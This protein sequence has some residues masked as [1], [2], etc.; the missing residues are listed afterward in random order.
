MAKKPSDKDKDTV[1]ADEAAAEK[2]YQ[3]TLTNAKKDETPV[4]E[5]VADMHRRIESEAGGVP[6]T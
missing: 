2:A 3:K 6:K 5:S 4:E 1:I